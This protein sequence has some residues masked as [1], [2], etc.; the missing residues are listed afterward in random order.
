MHIRK[1]KQTRI[2]ELKE[3][4]L[5]IQSE[6]VPEGLQTRERLLEQLQSA[7]EQLNAAQKTCISLY[8]LE[9]HSY[10]EIVTRT[11]YNGDQV[12][13]YIQNGKRNLKNYI[14]K[15]DPPNG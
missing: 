2:E 11:G 1:N 13:S 6:G 14:I 10:Q 4:L 5:N 8:Y 3:E 15:N 7:L 9:N 12:K